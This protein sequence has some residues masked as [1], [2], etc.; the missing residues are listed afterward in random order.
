MGVNPGYNNNDFEIRDP[1][2]ARRL[3]A[4]LCTQAG[5]TQARIS[6]GLCLY[7]V[8]RG[9]PIGGEPVAFIQLT[10]PI[11]QEK[12]DNLGQLGAALGQ[13]FV[14]F[15]TPPDQAEKISAISEGKT[16]GCVIDFGLQDLCR[17]AEM[18]QKVAAREAKSAG[19][20]VSGTCFKVYGH[21]V[22]R[23]DANPHRI[24]DMHKWKRSIR[25]ICRQMKSSQ[26]PRF[27]KGLYYDLSNS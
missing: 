23:L 18:W 26:P 17:V 15:V 27:D 12:I 1:D 7:A 25:R 21:V 5:L 3:V 2:K 19:F 8:D 6:G 9:C 11:S 4:R 22:M 24:T 16:A 10:D 14:S 13:E 20:H